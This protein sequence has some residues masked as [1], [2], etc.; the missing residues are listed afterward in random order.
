MTTRRSVAFSALPSA[1][2]FFGIATSLSTPASAEASARACGPP[3][4]GMYYC[5]PL[6]SGSSRSSGSV[7]YKTTGIRADYSGSSYK[8]SVSA[9]EKRSGTN[10][11]IWSGSTNSGS[12]AKTFSK[13]VHGHNICANDGT[14]SNYV[15]C[16]AS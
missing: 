14:K 12:L 7:A 2:L 16:F 13:T 4:T 15:R 9:Y 6:S 8:V 10:V 11:R 1:V 3:I 5:G